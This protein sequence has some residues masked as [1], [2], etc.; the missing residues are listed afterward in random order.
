MEILSYIILQISFAPQKTSILADVITNAIQERCRCVFTRDRITDGVFQCFPDSPQAVTYRATLHGTA[1]LS[2]LGLL[3]FIKDWSKNDDSATDIRVDSILLRVDHVCDVTITSI[4]D[5][6][7]GLNDDSSSSNNPMLTIILGM[8]GGVAVMLILVM[9]MIVI[10]F[11]YCNNCHK[12][13]SNNN[14]TLSSFDSIRY[15]R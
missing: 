2:A 1:E 6:E 14:H 11:C 15:Q 13:K 7:C 5:E 12:N 3:D 9:F 4:S 10:S 8:V